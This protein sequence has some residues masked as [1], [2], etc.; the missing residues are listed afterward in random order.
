MIQ[1]TV[2]VT[3][4]LEHPRHVLQLTLMQGVFQTSPLSIILLILFQL[5]FF[6]LKLL[7][8]F[9]DVCQQTSNL[10]PFRI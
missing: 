7:E 3:H 8:S 6:L 9:F 4:Q 1:I 5:C 2:Y 10:L